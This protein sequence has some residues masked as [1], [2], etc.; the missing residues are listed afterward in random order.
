MASQSHKI[1]V[2]DSSSSRH[3][4]QA[5]SSVNP[6]SKRCPFRWQCPVNGPTIHLNWSLFNFNRSF[7]LLAE[8]PDIS[9]F[10]CLSPVVDSHCFLWFLFVQSN[11]FL[12]LQ[13]RCRMVVQVLW[14]D[15]QIL[16]LPATFRFITSNTL[17]T[18]YPISWT[19]LCL[20]MCMRDWWQSQASSEV[21]WCLPSALIAA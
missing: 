15:V 3:L 17:M 10:T 2:A 13:L 8:G 11:R 20:A 6:S 16:F 21:I 19:L 12:E 5:G 9:L 18:W 14:T 4:S 7:I 1:C